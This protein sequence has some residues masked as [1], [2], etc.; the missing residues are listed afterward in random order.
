MFHASSVVSV[1]FMLVLFDVL[2]FIFTYLFS[3]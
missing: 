3:P 1:V 2:A